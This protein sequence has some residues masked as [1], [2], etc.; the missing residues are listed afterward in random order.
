MADVMQLTP[1]TPTM[2]TIIFGMS[3]APL[4]IMQTI[5]LIGVALRRATITQN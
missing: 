3:I 5:T 2:W 4:I 1:P